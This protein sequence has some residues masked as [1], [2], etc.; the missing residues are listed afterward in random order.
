MPKGRPTKLTK[1]R[2]DKMVEAI[3]MGT[4][5]SMACLQAKIS[6]QTH[7]NWYLK[8]QAVRERID[9]FGIELEEQLAPLSPAD[10]AQV[11]ETIDISDTD[12]RYL[13]YFDKI[14][15]A[16]GDAGELFLATIFNAAVDDPTWAAWMLQHRFPEDFATKIRGSGEDG[17]LTVEHRIDPEQYR[18]AIT[19]LADALGASLP[20][21]DTDG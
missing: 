11:I 20:G 1:A 14:K 7:R 8:G 6:Y 4:P 3:Q 13:D 19:A 16:E 2:T 9:A 15:G 17:A 10:R 18:R 12:K 5:I 21:T